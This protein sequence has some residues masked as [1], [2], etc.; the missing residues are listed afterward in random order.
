[1]IIS[2]CALQDMSVVPLL[3]ALLAHKTIS[4]LDLSHNMLGSYAVLT[5]LLL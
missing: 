5:F 2:D 1:V 4:M 3:D